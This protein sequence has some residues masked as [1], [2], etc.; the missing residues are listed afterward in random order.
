MDRYWTIGH[1]GSTDAGVALRW[2]AEN[3]S[4][5]AARLQIVR[6]WHSSLLESA[7]T[8]VTRGATTPRRPEVA[9]VEELDAAIADISAALG[10]AAPT[11]EP[12]VAE[13]RPSPTLLEAT[14]GSDL[15]VVGR[16][17]RGGFPG[18]ALGSVSQQ[19]ATH[20]KLPVVVVPDSTEQHEGPI[21]VGVDGSSDSSEALRWA[22]GFA[23]PGETVRALGIHA[24]WYPDGMEPADSR[25]TV[26]GRA[27]WADIEAAAASASAAADRP[28]VTL[29]V[30]YEA[31][32]PRRKLLEASTTSSMVVVGRHGSARLDEFLLGSVA[33]SLAARA[34]CPVAIVPL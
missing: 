31:G 3:S 33:L 22:L 1:D 13:G 32:D 34:A 20:A 26:S 15:L 16:R 2:A 4:G 21:T 23:R 19:C 14:I 9:A 27:Q 8:A 28:D 18:L 30:D 12:I 29:D 10:E 5:R 25:E 7:L 17:G 24:G 6:A 11:I